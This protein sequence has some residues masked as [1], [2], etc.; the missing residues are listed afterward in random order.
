MSNSPT[1]GPLRPTSSVAAPAGSP[2]PRT[3]SVST[4]TGR[5][6][7][8]PATSKVGWGTPGDFN[9][10]RVEV[11]EEIAENSPDKVRFLNQIC[12]QWHHDALGFW[13]G[14][15]PTEQRLDTGDPAPA[16]SLVAAGGPKAPASWFD[17]PE[18]G[19]SSP[20]SPSPTRAGSSVTW[21]SGRPATSATPGC[22]SPPRTAS[23]D[24]AYYA[25]GTVLL[26]DGGMART[27]G[28]QP[29]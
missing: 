15:A 27:G 4:T 21:R 25:S 1:T 7:A 12:A 26:D 14:H 28:H 23:T 5:C 6:P 22:A 18:P 13:P 24:Y 9:R 16:L 19:P 3:P 29:R 2:T 8:S 17:E 11:G 10:C 20:T